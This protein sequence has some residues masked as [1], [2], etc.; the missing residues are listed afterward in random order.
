M[1]NRGASSRD[2]GR[3]ARLADAAIAAQALFIGGWLVLGQLEGNGY[4]AGRHDI[5]D[6]GALTARHPAAWLA[7]LGIAGALTMA[8]AIG[9][10]R[11]A[12]TV[13]GRPR[14]VSPWLVALSLPALDN[15]GDV[16]F[17]LDCR[18]ADAGC[19]ASDAAA[20]WHGKAHLIVF[21]VAVIPTLIAPFALAHR[22]KLLDQWQDLVGLA[23]IFGVLLL[24][25]IVVNAVTTGMGVQGWTQRGLIVFV[26]AGVAAL[27]V[28]VR[29]LA[30]SSDTPADGNQ[31]L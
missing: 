24:V 14:P 28:R 9:A 17:R 22:M 13:A 19:S 10:L 25:G 2:G 20:S 3:T 4:S 26:C 30:S 18:A 1:L 27:A 23:R 5:S 29:R 11:P 8:F 21:A 6:L 16:F 7:V 31:S 15:L 12:L